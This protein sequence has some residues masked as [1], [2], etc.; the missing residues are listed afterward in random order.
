MISAVDKVNKAIN[1]GIPLKGDPEITKDFTK[2]KQPDP[3]D[4]YIEKCQTS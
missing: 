4:W 1:F 2:F 3:V